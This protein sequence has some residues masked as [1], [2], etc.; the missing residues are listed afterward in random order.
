[1]QT[2]LFGVAAGQVARL[3]VLN[4]VDPASDTVDIEM[5]ILDMSGMLLARDARRVG[6]GEGTFIEVRVDQRTEVRALV[7]MAGAGDINNVN[8][9]AEIIDND[10]GRTTYLVTATSPPA[11]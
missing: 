6:P 4:A 10:T 3:N 9:T 8:A 1:M 5:Q 2:G 11:Q 7:K